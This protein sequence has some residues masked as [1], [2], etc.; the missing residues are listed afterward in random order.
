MQPTRR[1]SLN[2]Q[3]GL[4]WVGL[5]GLGLVLVFCQREPPAG[6]GGAARRATATATAYDAYRR[7]AQ[8]VAALHIKPGDWIAEIGAGSGYLTG[9]L[10]QAVG[11]TGRVVAT[12]VD[13]AALAVLRERTRGLAQVESRRVGASEPGLEPGR[14]DLIL[15]AQV[16]HLLVDRVVYLRALQ[17]ALKP[18]GRIAVSNS[19]RY[20]EP[21]R[22][23]L[24]AVGFR[25]EEPDA[26]LPGQFLFIGWPR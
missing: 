24:S 21:L 3:R 4:R 1:S 7:P 8:L 23:A 19:V 15:L 13:D 14:Y 26:Q 10:A 12:D 5:C 16:D 6:P 25:C 22:A 11:T 18:S 17:R 20:R 2:A 9:R